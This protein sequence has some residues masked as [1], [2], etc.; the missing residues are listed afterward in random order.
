MN[1]AMRRKDDEELKDLKE[2]LHEIK[3]DQQD[4]KEQYIKN[5]VEL[6]RMADAQ[7]AFNERQD[8][9]EK[10]ITTFMEEVKPVIDLTKNM[11]FTRKAA[12]WFLTI[13]GTVVGILLGIKRLI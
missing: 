5:G 4:F 13:V 9:L 10:T 2:E 11:K 12:V 8:R 3:G 1:E 6:V 7:H